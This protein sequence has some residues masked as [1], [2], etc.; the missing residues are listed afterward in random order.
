M[1]AIE[2]VS[3]SAQRVMARLVADLEL[4]F[5]KAAGAALA[6]RF[7][8]AEECDI[9]WDMRIAE[10]WLGAWDSSD[11]DAEDASLEL[12]RIAFIG[13]CDGAWFV[14]TGVVDG[15]GQAH[16]LLGRRSLESEAQAREALAAAH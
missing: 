10:R 2:R 16:A 13:R 8:E 12:D 11:I 14:A 3:A 6:H 5:G 4:E 9:L 1:Q 15:D 7:L